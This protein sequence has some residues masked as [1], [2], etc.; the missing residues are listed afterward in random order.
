MSHVSESQAVGG[1]GNIYSPL[2]RLGFSNRLMR[3]RGRPR[4]RA[5]APW[6]PA[7]QR[8]PLATRAGRCGLALSLSALLPLKGHVG[9]VALIFF[10]NS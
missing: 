9:N 10:T 4:E 1:G 2:R 5:L 6:P 8:L 7:L 3:R